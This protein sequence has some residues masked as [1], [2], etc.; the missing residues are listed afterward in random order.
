MGLLDR[1]HLRLKRPAPR[2]FDAVAENFRESERWGNRLP[3]PAPQ[4]FSL[5]PLTV[6]FSGAG[7]VKL[8]SFDFAL[9]YPNTVLAIDLFVNV[10]RTVAGGG[11]AGFHVYIDGAD[12]DST[13]AA[14]MNEAAIHACPSM[15]YVTT[16]PLAGSHTLE[17][18]GHKTINA[19]T[20]DYH[21]N[22]RL[23]V[24]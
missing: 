9:A 20:F 24:L 6:P 21:G 12:V 10:T 17:L 5:S 14:A 3:I 16:V 4:I 23:W 7:E 8:Q 2:D 1:Y 19:G 13:V 15:G 11:E 18:W 22:L